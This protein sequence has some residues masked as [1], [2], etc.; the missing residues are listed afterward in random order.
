MAVIGDLVTGKG[1]VW[2]KFSEEVLQG[3]ADVVLVVTK[4]ISGYLQEN[5]KDVKRVKSCFELLESLPESGDGTLFIQEKE[6]IR[7]ENE[8]AGQEKDLATKLGLKPAFQTTFLAYLNV[9]SNLM[10][11]NSKK[12][13]KLLKQTLISISKTIIPR[14]QNPLLLA[15]FLMTCLD[16]NTDLSNQIYAL[17]G[18]FLLLQH[19]SLD[20]PQYYQ[21]LYALLLP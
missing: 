6:E 20:C 9:L 12:T 5:A 4:A 7:D 19:Y 10:S 21:K 14:L 2:K 3:N 1:S 11:T 17:K 13:Q 16:D 18:L 15:D 8:D